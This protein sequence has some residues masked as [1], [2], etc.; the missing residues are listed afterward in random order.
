MVEKGV[1]AAAG[2][3]AMLGR[4]KDVARNLVASNDGITNMKLLVCRKLENCLLI[5]FLDH[6][7]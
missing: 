2:G 6:D 1:S 7:S 5:A 4:A 3:R